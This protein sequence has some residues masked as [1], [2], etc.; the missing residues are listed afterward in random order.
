[1]IGIEAEWHPGEGTAK[2]H[3]PYKVN[4]VMRQWVV[5]SMGNEDIDYLPLW[6]YPLQ[7]SKESPFDLTFPSG[8]RTQ[9]LGAYLFHLVNKGFTAEQAFDIVRLMNEYVFENPIPPP[10]AGCGNT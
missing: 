1:M 8:D 3:I 5:G 6:L 2:T 7:K 10:N 4:G 9:K